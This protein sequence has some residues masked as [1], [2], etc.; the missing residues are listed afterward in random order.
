M[1]KCEKL[2][3]GEI[4]LINRTFGA[5]RRTCVTERQIARLLFQPAANDG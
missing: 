3:H 1:L 4:G 2:Y 5:A